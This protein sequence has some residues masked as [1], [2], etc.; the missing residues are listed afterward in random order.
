MPLQD[1]YLNNIPVAYP[2]QVANMIPATFISRTVEDEAGIGLGLPV[3][4]GDN[5]NG[6]SATGDAFLGITVRERSLRPESPN[7][8]SQRESARLMTKG[9]I[10][11]Q[12]GSTV[13]AGDPA[14]LTAEG[15]YS[16]TGATAIANGQ[17]DTSADADGF[18]VLRL[19]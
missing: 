12:V 16:A 17:F 14:T 10:W 7:V 8:F 15:D 18:A 19:A 6:C 3:F 11:V 9:A 4:Q 2:G 5:D 13:N 1:E